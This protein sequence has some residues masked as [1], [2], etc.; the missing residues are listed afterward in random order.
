MSTKSRKL[1]VIKPKDEA[2]EQA[3]EKQTSALVPQ[4]KGSAH[5]KTPVPDQVA[6][7]SVYYVNWEYP[8]AREDFPHALGDRFV[9]RMYPYAKPS[10]LLVD[11]ADTDEEKKICERK[12]T[13][14]R[15]RGM[16]YL[17]ISKGMTLEEAQQQL[18]EADALVN[19]NN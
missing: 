11:M 3:A 19:G 9:H 16:R 5:G 8:G 12:A 15:R 1:S 13:F 14:I 10:K 7:S 17:V 6:G 18:G 4:S 2:F